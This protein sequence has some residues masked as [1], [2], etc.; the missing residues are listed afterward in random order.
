MVA[1]LYSVVLRAARRGEQVAL[2]AD[3]V[4]VTG[5]VVGLKSTGNGISWHQAFDRRV[6][7]GDLVQT[8]Y[9]VLVVPVFED[10]SIGLHRRRVSLNLRAHV[11]KRRD[12]KTRR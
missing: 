5:D 9:K 10:S 2:F 3:W 12:E 1:C 4:W 6:A 11:P 7:A 8:R